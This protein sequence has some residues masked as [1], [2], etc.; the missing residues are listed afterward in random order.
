ML[1]TLRA[2]VLLAA[3]SLA[4]PTQAADTGDAA[5][6]SPAAAAASKTGLTHLATT[7]R[8]DGS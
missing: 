6:M 1:S 5:E 7:Q 4:V 2:G 3:F 8:D